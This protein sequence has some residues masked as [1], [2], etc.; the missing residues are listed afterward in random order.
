MHIID[1]PSTHYDE[2]KLP[3]QF[4]VLHYT[5]MASFDG[6]LDLLTGR[7]IDINGRVSAHYAISQKG[8]IY[9]LVDESKRAWHA[10]AGRYRGVTD[11]NSASI[12]IELD[13]E[14]DEY[15]RRHGVWQPY[16]KELMDSLVFLLRDVG[17][18][19]PH[20]CLKKDVLGHQYLAPR[21]KM[22]PGPHFP[23]SE[24]MRLLNQFPRQK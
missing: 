19:Y 12:G 3:L 8:D 22:D 17:Q 4:V 15:F 1:D 7:K 13:N 10:G 21:R 20:V 5:N 16:T 24:L 6:A 14:G 9:R 23:W 18:R 2:R 11:M